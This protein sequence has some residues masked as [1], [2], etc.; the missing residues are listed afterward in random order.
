MRSETRAHVLRAIACNRVPGFHF[1]GHFLDVRWRDVRSDSARLVLPDGRHFRDTRGNVHFLA[2]A[3]FVDVALGTAVRLQ[4][5]YRQRQATTYL[6]LQLTGIPAT[7]ELDA[8]VRHRGRSADSRADHSFGEATVEAD[9]GVIARAT[10][11]FARLG[12]LPGVA[13][14]PLPWQ[15]DTLPSSLPDESTLDASERA[16]LARCDRA[17]LD[18]GPAVPFVERFWGPD[19]PFRGAGKSARIAVGAHIG[20]RVGHV[21]GGILLGIAALAAERAVPAG[22]R[23]SN[24]SVWFLRPGLESLSVTSTLV[25]RG[26]T[27]ALVVTDVRS[28][29]GGAVIKAVTQ[30]V[31]A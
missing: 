12:P 30:H 21:Q 16:V 22:M 15:R 9:G 2:L 26:N 13:L 24:A 23:L 20:N 10:G 27:S 5:D 18:A 19:P 7:G 8:R 17:L 25:H 1:P 6:Q 28:D 31:T 14:G 3:V 11:T 29:D 4:D